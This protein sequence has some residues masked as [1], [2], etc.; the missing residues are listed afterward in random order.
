[1]RRVELSMSVK[2]NVTIPLGSLPTSATPYLLRHGRGKGWDMSEPRRYRNLIFD[3]QRWEG[4]QFRDDDIVISTPSKCGTTWMQMQCALVLFQDPALP[5][6]LTRLSPW[7]D[8]QTETR[9]SVVSVLEAQSHRRFIKT[10]TPLDGIPWDDRVLYITVGRDPRDVA[11][12]WDNHMG[13]LDIEKVL[14]QRIEVA[15]ADD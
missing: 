2:T 9:E 3:S 7:I 10:H 6:P 1:M 8:I 12:S 5:A 14:N 4:F 11:L 15:G 13:N